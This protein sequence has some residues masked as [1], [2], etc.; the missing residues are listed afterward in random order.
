MFLQE[1]LYGEDAGEIVMKKILV[2]GEHS[3]IGVSFQ[4]YV[5]NKQYDMVVTLTGAK[6]EAWKHMDFTEYDAIL[7]VAAI[8]HKKETPDMEPLYQKVNTDFPIELAKK[9][10]EGGV[11][12][13]IFLSTMAVYGKQSSPIS[14]DSPTEPVTMYGKSKLA[15]EMELKKLADSNFTVIVL[16]PPMVYGADCPGNYKR[17]AKLAYKLPVFPKIKN[18]RSMI[19]IENLCECICQQIFTSET[20]YDMICPQNAEYVNTTELVKEIRRAHG[21]GVLI[22]PFPQ[23]LIRLCAAKISMAEKVFGDCYYEKSKCCMDYQRWNFADSVRKT[24]E[25]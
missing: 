15:A 1:E 12:N 5:Q 11:K 22:V 18:Q 21:K 14:V 13:F 10:K 24:E 3:Y 20:Q 7:H 16:R 4:K 2:V 17:L 6:N 23:V 25:G 9:A 19:Y 8:V